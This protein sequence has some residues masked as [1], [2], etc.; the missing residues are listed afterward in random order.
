LT[1]W[2]DGDCGFCARV[3]KWLERQ[4][5]FVA[6]NCVA[7]QTAGTSSCPLNT[8]ELLDKLT[9]TASDGAVYR[10]T[11]AW[12]TLLWALRNYRRWSLRFARQSWRPWAEDLFATITGVAKLTQRQRKAHAAKPSP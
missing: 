10:G 8:A 2:F 7:A 6:V 5:K 1:V 3:A 9:V 4:P 11:N 12:I